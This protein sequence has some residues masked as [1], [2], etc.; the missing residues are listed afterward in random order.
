MR[1][2]DNFVRMLITGKLPEGVLVAAVPMARVRQLWK[3]AIIAASNSGGNNTLKLLHRAPD[4]E[5]GNCS[6]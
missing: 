2:W 4:D 3:V 5:E 1:K 6:K